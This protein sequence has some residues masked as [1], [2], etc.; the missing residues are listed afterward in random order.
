MPPSRHG[1]HS[2]VHGTLGGVSC[3]HAMWPAPE[4]WQSTP[5]AAWHRAA[6]ATGYARAQCCCAA[7]P[8]GRS[9]AAGRGATA[10]RPTRRP[11]PTVA[12]G[13]AGR[14]TR[15]P[16]RRGP[17]A[18]RPAALCRRSPARP[19]RLLM[20]LPG[21]EPRAALNQVQV[22]QARP[23][24][25]CPGRRSGRPPPAL[26]RQ[27]P[28]WRGAGLCRRAARCSR[29][30]AG[31]AR[32]GPSGGARGGR[33]RRGSARGLPARA[34]G[35]ARAGWRRLVA[36]VAGRRA[37]RACSAGPR[38]QYCNRRAREPHCCGRA[39]RSSPT[40]VIA[41]GGGGVSGGP[42]PSPGSFWAGCI[43]GLRPPT[44]AQAALPACVRQDPRG[45]GG[46]GQ[47]WPHGRVCKDFSTFRR[48][49]QDTPAVQRS[50]GRV[51]PR[52]LPPGGGGFLG[53]AARR[54]CGQVSQ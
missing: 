22:H 38:P 31:R 34:P 18:G 39:R 7:V 35:G 37:R 47:G 25:Q 43:R 26:G 5:H 32:V 24:R 4:A 8:A 46:R 1:A 42:G 16:A 11:G 10:R 48:A 23:L 14:E 36:A 17:P 9:A 19:E 28:R 15:Q 27:W 33:R 54:G 21:A 30:M 20:R 52:R 41:S 49:G 3:R 6:N 29:P 40:L 13:R 45:L 50:A 12:Q 44:P 53:W 2:R 51:T